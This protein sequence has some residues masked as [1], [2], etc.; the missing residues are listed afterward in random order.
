MSSRA[1]EA[2]GAAEVAAIPTPVGPLWLGVDR[3]EAPATGWSC[4]GPAPI[5][6]RSAP[7]PWRLAQRLARVLAGGADG[8]EDLPLPSGTPFQRLVWRETRRIPR[9]ATA[10]YGEIARAIGRPLAARAVGQAMRRNPAPV[11]VPCHRVV[12]IDGGGG[13]GGPAPRGTPGARVK[14]FLLQLEQGPVD[15]PRESTQGRPPINR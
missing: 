9:G 3:H 14:E 6:L 12:G 4:L 15:R 11:L 13:Y 5:D 8:F 1:T 7:V 2:F 10:T